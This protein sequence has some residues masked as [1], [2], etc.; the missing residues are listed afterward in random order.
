V[1]RSR[2]HIDSAPALDTWA[3]VDSWA[4]GAVDPVSIRARWSARAVPVRGV[5]HIVDVVGDAETA[6]GALRAAG[7]RV[8]PIRPARRALGRTGEIA[9][10][11]DDDVSKALSEADVDHRVVTGARRYL[12]RGSFTGRTFCEISTEAGDGGVTI[13]A[14]YEPVWIDNLRFRADRGTDELRRPRRVLQA[15]ASINRLLDDLGADPITI[16]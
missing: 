8:P 15:R 4:E 10:R 16:A 7:L 1:S 14:W 2:R 11:G 3:V 5:D 9:Y 6:R 13:E 12:W